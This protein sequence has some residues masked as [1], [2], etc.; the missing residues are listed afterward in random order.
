MEKSKILQVKVSQEL[1][2]YAKTRSK[3]LGMR[4]V[5]EFVRRLINYEQKHVKK[6]TFT[7]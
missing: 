6:N 5:S 1:F 4:S 3:E 2:K 7:F